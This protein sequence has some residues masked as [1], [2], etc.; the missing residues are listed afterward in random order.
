MWIWK[1]KN[2]PN[3]I[4]NSEAIAPVLERC[5]QAVAPLTE[6]SK[7]LTTDQR[8]DWEA[9]ILLDET[10][11]SAKIEGELLDRDSVRSS[12]VNK[13]GITKNLSKNKSFNLVSTK[14][15]NG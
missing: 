10:L 2:W 1:N 8:L 3:F 9:T 15:C 6:L 14:R 7:L 4:Y 11:F 5:I 13:L 12:I